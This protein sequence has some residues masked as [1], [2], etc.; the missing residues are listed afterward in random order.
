MYDHTFQ[1]FFGE[2][3]FRQDNLW[4]QITGHQR[5]FGIPGDVQRHPPSEW[6]PQQAVA[7]VEKL[8]VTIQTG[9]LVFLPQNQQPAGPAQQKQQAAASPDTGRGHH[10]RLPG[11]G[12]RTALHAQIAGIF[13]QCRTAFR[14]RWGGCTRGITGQLIR[15]V[16]HYGGTGLLRNIGFVCRSVFRL[17]RYQFDRRKGCGRRL[18]LCQILIDRVLRGISGIGEDAHRAWKGDRQH[19]PQQH[20]PPHC[21]AEPFGELFP[22]SQPDDQQDC[23]DDTG[24]QAGFQRKQK[25][26]KEC[27]H[28]ISSLPLLIGSA[29]RSKP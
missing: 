23:R 4:P 14:Y 24:G 26:G 12:I 16:R 29:G 19:Q 6:M 21:I 22:R 25:D 3:T 28:I 2:F 1:L 9:S 27:A 13:L 18:C 11:E 5:A 15:T 17:F 8:L 10:Q 20:Q 7:A